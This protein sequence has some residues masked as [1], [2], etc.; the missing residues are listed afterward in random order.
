MKDAIA[1]NRD[2]P[3]RASLDSH[4]FSP[5]SRALSRRGGFSQYMA[6]FSPQQ[7]VRV[8]WDE[9]EFHAA[10]ILS[11]RTELD[12]QNRTAQI[13][14]VR[15][16]EDGQV[17]WHH[18]SDTPHRP[19]TLLEEEDEGSWDKLVLRCD[20]SHARLTRPAKGSQCLH[21][22]RCNYDS[23]MQF[24]SLSRCCP[25]FGCSA[26]L[27]R[28]SMVTEDEALGAALASLPPYCTACWV[29]AGTANVRSTPPGGT[30]AIAAAAAPLDV[31]D[32][33]LTTQQRTRRKQG[34][35]EAESRPLGAVVVDVDDDASRDQVVATSTERSEA[36]KAEGGEVVT[37]AQGVK[38]HLSST[39]NTGYL[40]VHRNPSG[41][42]QASL[43]VDGRQKAV[44][45][46]DTAVEAAVAV[47]KCKSH[48]CCEEC[49][50]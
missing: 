33:L 14:Q 22:P 15:Y 42:Y 34:R 39:S 29:Q 6:A 30:S 36:A 43:R 41:R 23:L 45:T 13:L 7:R 28:Q 11:I 9:D 20:I 21:A 32:E 40:G 3:R 48:P 16:E 25:V 37:E 24:V 17:L 49:S 35:V 46:Y 8:Q 4:G 27:S 38:L 44:G 1:T 12:R 19:I 50:E 47:A 10:R 5:F 2:T 31:S 18:P 26:T